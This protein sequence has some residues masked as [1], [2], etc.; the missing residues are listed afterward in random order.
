[1][2]KPKP[3]SEEKVYLIVGGALINGEKINYAYEITRTDAQ[4]AKILRL[5]MDILQICTGSYELLRGNSTERLIEYNKIRRHL[6]KQYTRILNGQNSTHVSIRI[7]QSSFK[8]MKIMEKN[9]IDQTSIRLTN[10]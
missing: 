5:D 9:Q 7:F 1:M 2:E 4:K 3:T 6:E 10:V 8:Y